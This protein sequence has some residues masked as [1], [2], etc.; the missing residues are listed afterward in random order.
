MLGKNVYLFCSLRSKKAPAF[1]KRWPAV[2]P[3]T[4]VEKS[5]IEFVPSYLAD[6]TDSVIFI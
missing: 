6:S 4:L 2:R 5:L 3:S 1:L